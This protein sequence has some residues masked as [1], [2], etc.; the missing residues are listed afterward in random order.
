MPTDPTVSAQTQLDNEKAE[1]L[2]TVWEWAKDNII[3]ALIILGLFLILKYVLVPA[4][5]D[6]FKGFVEKSTNKKKRKAYS[7]TTD[8]KEISTLSVSLIDPQY[9]SVS[10]PKKV[11]E[12]ALTIENAPVD[13][14]S[15]YCVVC[16]DKGL[17]KHCAT[18]FYNRMLESTAVDKIGWVNYQKPRKDTLELCTEHCLFYDLLLFGDID[19]V[20]KR[21][22][23]QLKFFKQPNVHSLLVFWMEKDALDDDNVLRQIAALGGL[24]VIL[25]ATA[26]VSGYRVIRIPKK[27]GEEK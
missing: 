14:R 19:S 23:A 3:I 13:S 12:L 4:L 6:F 18:L 10:M 8:D 15:R 9:A 27:G 25:F 5:P 17:A 24:S 7:A 11:E 1:A 2:L 20:E 21:V 22:R 26:P 16:K